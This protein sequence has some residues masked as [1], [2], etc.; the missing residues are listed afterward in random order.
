[1][2][3][4]NCYVLLELAFDPPVT[5]AT[6]IK[7]A[8]HKKRQEWVRMQDTPGKRSIALYNLSLIP[9]IERIMLDP[10]LRAGEAA[11]AQE[12]RGEMLRQFEAELRIL[13]S[14]G[15]ITPREAAAITAKYSHYGIGKTALENLT[16]KPVSEN[17]PRESGDDDVGETLDRL[18]ARNVQRNLTLLGISDLYAFLDLPPYSSIKKLKDAAEAK[19]R[20]ASSS[21]AK[22]AQVTAVQEL[23]G[24]CLQLFSSFDTK[25]KYDRYLKISSYPA[26]GELV[27]DEFNRSK[28]INTDVLLRIINFAVEKYGCKVL[29]AEEYIRRYCQAYN[30]PIDSQ[31]KFVDC[32]ACHNKTDREGE[33][34]AVCAAPLRGLCPNCATPFEGGPSVCSKCGFSI[35][36]MIKAQQ[37]ISD[38]ENA[39]IESN[40]SSAQ[41][42]IAY[43][44]KFW[45]GHPRLDSLE[46]RAK[47]LEDRYATYVD[48]IGD[49]VK[50]NQYYAAVELIE[51]AEARRIRLPASTTSHVSKVIADF[52]KRLEEITAIGT[53]PDFDVLYAMVN[54][55]ADSIEL[56]RLLAMH[57]PEP[58]SGMKVTL[59]D[60]KVRV[61]WDKSPAKGVISYVLVRKLESA[62]LTAYDGDILYEGRANSF[63]DL[64]PAPL[65]RFYYSV[66]VRRGNAYSESSALSEPILII[67]EVENLRIVPT[68]SGARISWSFNPDLREVLV[69]RKLGGDRP[70]R[71]GD[72][73]LLENPRLDG[74]SDHKLKNDVEYWYYIVSVY[75]LDG[76]RVFSKGVCDSVIPHRLL[77]PIDHIDIMRVDGADGEYVVNW[78]NSQYKDVLVLASVK[79]PDFRVGETLPVSELIEQYRNLDLDAKTPESARLRCE[80]S[81]GLYIFAAAVSGKYATVGTPRYLTNV[82][83]VEQLTWDMV[84]SDLFFNMKWPQGTQEI[85]IMW[86]FD[87]YPKTP[88]EPG[89]ISMTCTREQYEYDAGALLKDPEKSLYYFKIFSVFTAP[90]GDRNYS[91]GVELRI[92]LTPQQEIFYQLKYTKSFF[93]SAYSVSLTISSDSEF[94]LPRAVIVGKIGRL[95]LKKTDGMPLFEIEKETKVA[96]SITYE[97]RTSLL[98]K[99]LHV[100]LFLRDEMF[101]DKFRLLPVASLKI[102]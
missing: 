89:T 78:H 9:E 22:N 63:E 28:Y 81:G 95:P 57:P 82:L 26:V 47:R 39:L 65:K 18:V 84:N 86:R 20:E 7:A 74:L 3:R 17:P 8:I 72:G 34:C 38:A 15:H 77:A 19:R 69:W 21:G 88:G 44:G 93:A 14:K 46:R 43:A 60:K 51:E 5:D 12:L 54:T 16:R 100:K 42:C 70:L 35:A 79:K 59:L 56:G 62:P 53:A 101:Y 71:R 30:I 91:P 33:L 32:P 94:V 85:L 25:Q 52:E 66:Y 4:E 6:A 31:S 96:G 64:N 102:T 99:N 2:E 29:E 13:E 87:A 58:V 83:D 36:E 23:S 48:N 41:R 55:V 11:A 92:D 75:V 67:P 37:Y 98:P 10:A 50:H 27:D 76:V 40:W 73:M 97:Y 90:D 1:M 80:F 24:I 45:P 68:D 61:D 49:C